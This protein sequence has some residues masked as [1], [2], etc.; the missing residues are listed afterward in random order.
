MLRSVPYMYRTGVLIGLH[1][2]AVRVPPGVLIGLHLWAA[3]WPVRWAFPDGLVGLVV[4]EVS[5]R[6]RAGGEA[7]RLVHLNCRSRLITG[8]HCKVQ[9]RGCPVLKAKPGG[10]QTERDEERQM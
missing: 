1:L 9:M 7:A 5:A 6:E 8:V 3:L 2:W 10:S 4:V